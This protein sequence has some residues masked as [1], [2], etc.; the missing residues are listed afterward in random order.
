M[1]FKICKDIEE[2]KTLWNLFSPNERLFDNW[3]YRAC[4]LDENEHEPYFIVG[5]NSNSVEGFIPL[6]YVK[7]KSQY[8]Y[9]GGWFTAERNRLFVKDKAKIVD[10][11]EQCPENTYV[12][13]MDPR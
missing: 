1:N 8:N 10:F 2:C 11:L 3:D 12:E 4:F 13:G 5:Y 6:V 9:L 7:G